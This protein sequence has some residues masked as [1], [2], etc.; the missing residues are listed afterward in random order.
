MANLRDCAV[1]DRICNTGADHQLAE[2]DRQLGL[3]AFLGCAFRFADLGQAELRRRRGPL[4][5]AEAWCWAARMLSREADE[6]DYAGPRIPDARQQSHELHE[7]ADAL[8][9]RA[10]VLDGSRS[11]WRR[12]LAK[13]DAPSVAE[14]RS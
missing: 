11:L 8:Y 5:A 12:A 6:I 2:I 1:L 7:Q 10:T 3:L 13:F 4:T 14:A 9:A